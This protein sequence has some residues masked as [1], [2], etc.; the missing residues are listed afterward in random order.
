M[1]LMVICEQCGKQ[2]KVREEMLGKRLKCPACQ[3]VFTAAAMDASGRTVKMRPHE[4][5][6]KQASLADIF[7]TKAPEPLNSA[8]QAK[9]AAT[10][11]RPQK[12]VA[13]R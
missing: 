3:N 8:K 5:Q 13:S 7:M 9:K 6:Q 10:P 2:L 11:T 1:P 12:R 4:P